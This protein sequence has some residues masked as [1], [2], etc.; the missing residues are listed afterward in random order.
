M[1]ILTRHALD[2]MRQ[3]WLYREWVE[4]A[5]LAPDWIERDPRPG[6]LRAFRSVPERGG[7]I[8][9]VAYRPQDDDLIVLSAHFDRDAKP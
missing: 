5:V 1:I 9:R 4:R 6:I 8:L 2:R 3:E 7:R